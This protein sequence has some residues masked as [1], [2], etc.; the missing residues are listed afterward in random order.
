[1]RKFI[2]KRFALDYMCKVFGYGF[3]FPRAATF[4]FPLFVFAGINIALDEDFPVLDT[5]DILSLILLAIPVFI[6]F[7]YLRIKPV[8]ISELD[9]EQAFQAGE[10]ITK[11][12]VFY[13]LSVEDIETLTNSMLYIRDFYVPKK[14]YKP[15]LVLFHPMVIVPLSVLITLIYL[16]GN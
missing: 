6:S 14:Y 15:W 1:M 7:V 12:I 16:N 5:F 9:E 2:V 10:A 13:D 8:Q 3:N 11:Q 4:I